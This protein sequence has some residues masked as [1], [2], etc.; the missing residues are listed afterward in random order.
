MFKD[1]S[2]SDDEGILSKAYAKIAE[3]TKKGI[4][5]DASYASE[6]DINA[7]SCTQDSTLDSALFDASLLDTSDR[8]SE[9]IESVIAV[10][11]APLRRS[12]ERIEPVI[13]VDSA[14][15]RRSPRI[16]NTHLNV[17]IDN[18]VDFITSKRRRSARRVVPPEHSSENPSTQKRNTRTKRGR[19]RKNPNV[20]CIGSDEEDSYSSFAISSKSNEKAIAGS[21]AVKQ[22]DVILLGSDD[23]TPS[24]NDHLN[25]IM[26]VKIEWMC[27]GGLIIPHGRAEPFSKIYEELSRTKGYDVNKIVLS[28][29][30]GKI[31]KH[32]ETPLSIKLRIIDILEGSISSKAIENEDSHSTEDAD[33]EIN[34][35][36]LLNFKILVEGQKAPSYVKIEKDQTMHVLLTKLAGKLNCS[37]D[38][39]RLWFDGEMVRLQDTPIDLDLEGDECF[40]L[41]FKKK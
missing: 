5:P 23:E 2:D 21:K 20:I 18:D 34:N 40:E 30:N 31:V 13:V 6:S 11:S 33:S 26:N 29:R 8:P 39:M 41:K 36:N 37:V 27:E 32:H 19:K 15:V 17:S 12:P 4:D 25:D 35:K 28:T 16:K 10:D 24:R 9:R 7:A 22:N 3:K 38:R 14:P 1:D